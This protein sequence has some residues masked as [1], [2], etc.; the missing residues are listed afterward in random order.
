MG[1]PRLDI[2]NPLREK[3]RADTV[4]C[5]VARWLLWWE[6]DLTFCRAND[7]RQDYFQLGTNIIEIIL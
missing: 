6:S 3:E 4:L 2:L 1:S 5:Q 7:Y